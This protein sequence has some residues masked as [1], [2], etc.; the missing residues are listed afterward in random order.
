MGTQKLELGTE[1]KK[2]K[3]WINQLLDII[4]MNND[5]YIYNPL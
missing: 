1:E 2:K 4:A 3:S 5:I